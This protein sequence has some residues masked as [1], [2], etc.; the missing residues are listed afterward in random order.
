[1]KN[2]KLSYL[3][4]FGLT[5]E[6]LKLVARL[7][8]KY[9]SKEANQRILKWRDKLILKKLRPIVEHVYNGLDDGAI[10][11]SVNIWTMWWQ[12]EKQMPDLVKSCVN[13]LKK[14]VGQDLIIITKDNYKQYVVLETHIIEKVKKGEITITHLSDIIRAN[15]LYNYGGLWLDA[16]M[17]A[18]EKFELPYKD[19][20]WTLREDLPYNECISK[21][22]WC[23]FCMYMPKGHVFSK[24]LKD[25]FNCYWKVHNSLIDY[26]LID[27]L[28]EYALCTIPTFKN[29]WTNI[30]TTA[31]H[32]QLSKF[33]NAE[34]NKK[35]ENELIHT[36]PLHKLQR[37][38]SYILETKNGD[39]T[40]YSH[41]LEEYK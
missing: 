36:V 24:Y 28:T 13:S 38:S 31:N 14:N 2:K 10:E 1:M 34:Y 7:A 25:A 4:E 23:G 16:L 19:K 3:F 11:P 37:R 35:H 30:P 6:I 12:G 26:F 22:R 17:F 33:L 15:L 41:I 5:I 20:Y 40:I 9:I 39:P 21:G 32:F 8:K 18:S 27:Y 29:E